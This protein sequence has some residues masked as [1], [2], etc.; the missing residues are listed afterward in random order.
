MFKHPILPQIFFFHLYLLFCLDYTADFYFL[1]ETKKF[2][3]Q[4]GALT[5]FV[6]L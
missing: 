4:P 6:W 3:I 1:F 2:G 5:G